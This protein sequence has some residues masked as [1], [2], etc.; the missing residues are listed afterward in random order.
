MDT[1]N[2]LLIF[3]LCVLV[4][5]VGGVVYEVFSILRLLLKCERGKNKPLGIVLDLLFCG[6]FAGLC[7]V[8]AYYL[9]F[10]AFRI[11]MWIGYLCGF[12]IYLKILHRILAFLE[13]LCYN[14]ITKIVK[15]H[16][17]KKNSP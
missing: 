7:V 8:S 13:K 5:F 3:C 16:K 12:Y 1:A 6:L 17:R 14:A 10:P 15:R 9:H 11:Y 4:G 2:Q